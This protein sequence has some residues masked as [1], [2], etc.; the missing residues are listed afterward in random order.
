[1]ALSHLKKRWGGKLA[2]HGC[3]STAGPLAYGTAEDVARNVRDTLA[4]MMPG[5]GYVLSPTHSIQDNSPT[6]NVVA[7]YEA[8]R[9]HGQ[10][11]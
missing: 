9:K 6:A 10:Y 11:G 8:G 5:G 3:I 4:I 1:M 7:M 2:F